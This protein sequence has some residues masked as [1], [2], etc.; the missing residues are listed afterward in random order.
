LRRG[1]DAREMAMAIG[2]LE[3]DDERDMLGVFDE[4]LYTRMVQQAFKHTIR[5]DEEAIQDL[6]LS[7]DIQ[8]SKEMMTND[9]IKL[10]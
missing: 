2:A 3:E 7:V 1:F 5:W 4:W 6:I 8:K 10:W 9:K